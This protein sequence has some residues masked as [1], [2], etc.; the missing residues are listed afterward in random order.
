MRD[1]FIVL[2]GESLLYVYEAV[3]LDTLRMIVDDLDD[4]GFGSDH[5]HA[6]NAAAKVLYRRELEAIQDLDTLV[7]EVDPNDA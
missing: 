4:P 2:K 3:G 1:D 6:V 7:V 5:I